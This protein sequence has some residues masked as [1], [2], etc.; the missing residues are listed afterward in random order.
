[1]WTKTRTVIPDRRARCCAVDSVP[2]RTEVGDVDL[3]DKTALLIRELSR[4]GNHVLK[5]AASSL[6]TT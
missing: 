6:C 4:V 5:S 2:F 1:M 3:G